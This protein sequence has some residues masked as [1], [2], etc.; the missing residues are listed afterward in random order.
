[1]MSLLLFWLRKKYRNFV[2]EPIKNR[3]KD[4]IFIYILTALY[5]LCFQGRVVLV[6]PL[7]DSQA[8]HNESM[9][10]IIKIAL[11]MLGLS[12]LVALF[13][14]L[15]EYIKSAFILKVTA[16]VRLNLFK[17]IVNLDY[18]YFTKDKIG[19]FI[20]RLTSDIS[21]IQYI[22]GFFIS[23]AAVS[24]L[25]IFASF[26]VATYICLPLA[27]MIFVA[28]PII[29][30]IIY[31]LTRRIKKKRAEAQESFTEV[32]ENISEIL[33]NLKITK[34]FGITQLKIEDFSNVNYEYTRKEKKLAKARSLNRAVIELLYGVGFAALFI[35]SGYILIHKLF[36]LTI[37][38]FTA[39]LVN[40][41][42]LN[43]PV[44]VLLDSYQGLLEAY[45][46]LERIYNI[47]EYPKD[48]YQPTGT[49]KLQTIQSIIFKDVNFA[50][51]S[52]QPVLKDIN[53]EINKGD[54]VWIKG[55]SGAGKSSL[56]DLICGFLQPTTGKILINGVEIEKINRNDLRNLIT[57]I[58]NESVLF[59][60]TIKENILC[61]KPD[62][63]EEEF[64]ASLE[65]S[66][67][68]E[69][70]KKVENGVDFVVGPL[71]CCLSSG[72]RQRVAL[73]RAFL[74]KSDVYLLDEP[75]SNLDPGSESLI[76]KALN[77]LSNNKIV[78]ITSHKIPKSLPITKIVEL[79]NGNIYSICEF[80]NLSNT[81]V[82]GSRELNN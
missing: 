62:S 12:M 77:N 17:E 14:F 72:Q 10:I 64:R 13:G 51:I 70:L 4:I 63:S 18:L 35:L 27:L 82:A 74:K 67:V 53:L 8:T 68:S 75:F 9:E 38:G 26:L 30:Y 48:N 81:E 6:K 19:N 37:G 59:N 15:L 29:Y 33:H 7:L 40:I 3:Y 45:V 43:K 21:Q 11:G 52:G 41:V 2:I 79:R 16:N 47:F 56:L 31:K 71:G 60:A 49:Q 36:G 54:F 22:Y 80:K 39:F 5:S 76:E 24:V 32:L 66:S 20:N 46:S 42:T 50:Y 69:F 57:L 1:M 61:V 78:I 25:M 23:S 55:P 44:K 34:L 58:P 73:A 28:A 65:N